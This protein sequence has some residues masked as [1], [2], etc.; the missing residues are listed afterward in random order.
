MSEKTPVLIVDDDLSFA[1]SLSDILGE[2]DYNAVTV[3]SGEEAL[4]KVKEENFQVILMDIKLSV[5]NGVET[6]KKIKEIAPQIPVIMMTAFSVENLVKDAL[7]EG[8][9]GVLH[10]P[11]DIERVIKMI[12]AIRKGGCSVMIVNNAPDIHQILKD[13]LEDKGYVVILA[14]DGEEAISIARHRPQDIIFLSMKLSGLNGLQTY[15]T[16]QKTN[17]NV[18]VVLMSASYQESEDLAEQA[19]KQ[20]AYTH[21]RKPFDIKEAVDIVEEIVRKRKQNKENV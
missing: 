11:L 2:K 10:K 12:E 19:L 18:A 9:Y 15:L 16:I 17:P 1:E 20:G 14:E 6:H 4:E 7:K 3:N 8:A 21:I 5:M 13:T